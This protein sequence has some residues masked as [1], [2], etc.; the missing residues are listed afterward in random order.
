M[1]IYWSPSS[2]TALAESE[3]EYN[4]NH[5]SISIYVKFPLIGANNSFIRICAANQLVNALVWMMTFWTLPANR[6]ICFNPEV[7]YA[8]VRFTEKEDYEYY[9]IAKECVDRL[10]ETFGKKIIRKYSTTG[11]GNLD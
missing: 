4:D 5:Q 9:L 2:L 6:A 11:V 1:P 8:T 7:E 3:L 10:K